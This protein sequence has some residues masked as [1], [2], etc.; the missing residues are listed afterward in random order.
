MKDRQRGQI[1]LIDGMGA[2]FLVVFLYVVTGAIGSEIDRMELDTIKECEQE[3]LRSEIRDI[4]PEMNITSRSLDADSF[5]I[6]GL[7]FVERPPDGAGFQAFFLSDDVGV[8][9]FYITKKD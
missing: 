9:L 1:A 3:A 4:I 6:G 2:L 5:E 7:R 8:K